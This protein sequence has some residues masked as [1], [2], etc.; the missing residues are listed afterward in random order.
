MCGSDVVRLSP[1]GHVQD[2]FQISSEQTDSGLAV[3]AQENIYIAYGTRPHFEKWSRDGTLLASWGVA[4]PVNVS[5]SPLGIVV[6]SAGNI[7]V[8]NTPQNF[9]EQFGPS[10]ALLGTWGFHGSYAGQF[11]HPGGIAVDPRGAIYVAD[12]DNHRVQMLTP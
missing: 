6:D 10:G 2:V 11:H 12:T 1:A 5:S 8:A 9:I 4:R 7:Y 3:D